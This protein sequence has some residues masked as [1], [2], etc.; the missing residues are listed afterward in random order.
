MVSKP[1]IVAPI[2]EVV[3]KDFGLDELSKIKGIGKKT[4]LDIKK[5]FNNVESLKKALLE[6]RVGLRD[7]IVDKL[8]K[9]LIK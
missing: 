9:E 6:D 3:K 5:M 7:D 2:L 4:V 1:V 8:K